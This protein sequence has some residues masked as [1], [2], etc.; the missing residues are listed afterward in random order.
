MA[1]PAMNLLTI[2]EF[3][4]RIRVSKSMAYRL[5]E[6]QQVRHV[7]I[8]TKILVPEGAIPEFLRSCEVKP[9]LELLPPA[10]G[11]PSR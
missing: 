7:R 6:E 8:G 4:A 11:R 5:V 1:E 2:A 3:A 10:D 9:L